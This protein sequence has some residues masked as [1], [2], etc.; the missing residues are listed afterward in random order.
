M[1]LLRVC[2]YEAIYRSPL[3]G[4]YYYRTG[5][6]LQE[7]NGIALQDFILRKMNTSWDTSPQPTATLEDID[8]SAVDFFLHSA[9]RAKRIDE[10]SLNDS[11]E[12]I[13]RNLRLINE[14][15]Q[16]T[17][18]A[19]LLFGKDVERWSL[20]AAFRIGR[21]GGSQADLIIHDNIVCPL[22]LMPGKVISTLRNNYLVSPIRYDGL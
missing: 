1:R 10:N 12:K 7:L 6:T 4:K 18:A 20:S 5:S 3:K 11:T 15:G 21:F 2:L 17:I 13:L 19:L 9:I 8:R 14:Y 16:L 22:I